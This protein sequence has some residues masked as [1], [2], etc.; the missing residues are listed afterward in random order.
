[1]EDDYNVLYGMKQKHGNNM[2]GTSNI[3]EYY[4]NNNNELKHNRNKNTFYDY[5]LRPVSAKVVRE[6]LSRNDMVPR[7][8]KTTYSRITQPPPLLFRTGLKT[9]QLASEKG[10]TEEKSQEAARKRNG[11]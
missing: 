7:E 6:L 3:N 8:S 9:T 2:K 4:N 1:M 11:L 5:H 10:R